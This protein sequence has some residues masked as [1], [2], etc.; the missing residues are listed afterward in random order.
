MKLTRKQF[1]ITMWAV[2]VVVTAWAFWT[3]SNMEYDYD[4][5]QDVVLA[6]NG[7]Y[8]AEVAHEN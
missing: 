5:A 1:E 2:A 6:K 7:A 4:L 3:V 8:M